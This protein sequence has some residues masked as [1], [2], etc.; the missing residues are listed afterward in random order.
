MSDVRRFDS[1]ERVV[2]DQRRRLDDTVSTVLSRLATHTHPGMGGGGV[3]D[4]GALTGLG[5]D[6]HTQYHT[7]ARGDVRYYLKATVDAALAAKAD[8]ADLTAHVGDTGNPHSVT[9]TQVGLGSVDNVSAANLRDRATHT[10]TQSADTLTDGTT[11]KAFLATERTKLSGIATG[12]TANS[13]DATLLARANHTGTQSA[14]TL[15]DGTT[16]KA[17]LATERTKLAGIATGATANSS[18]ATLLDRANHTGS[19][20]Q[21]TVTNLTTDLA[22]KQPLDSDLTAIAGLAPTNGD[23]IQRV[24]GAWTN[25]TIAQVKTDLGLATVATTGDYDDLIDKPTIP[26]AYTDEQVRDVIGAALVAGS[27]VTITPDDGAD[28]ITISATPGSGGVTDH[29]AL[30]GLGDDDHTQY[31]NDT[32]GDIRYYTK[33]LADAGFQPLDSDLTTIAGLSV[34]NGQLMR[35]V[36]GAWAA[37]TMSA[38]DIATGTLP[39]GQ[40]PTGTSGTTV[41]LGNHS[42]APAASSALTAAFQ[43]TTSTTYTDLTT[44]GAA[45]TVTV[46][47]SGIAIVSFTADIQIAYAINQSA[48]AWVS[49]AVSGAN[50]LAAD[51]TRAARFAFNNAGTGGTPTLESTMANTI[52]LTGLTTGSTTFTMKYK[53]STAAITAL[54]WQNRRINVVSF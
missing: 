37:Y 3:T 16:N 24:S 49:F 43:G 54:N 27:N 19:Q 22:G 18:D 32:R 1:I 17:F 40:V 15:T 53:R 9:K 52:V 46:G 26:A 47:S 38:T 2:R 44:A 31:H 41:A 29:G 42:H 11:N 14:D 30:T 5:D 35:R 7:D 21:G 23:L 8:D 28:T 36:S 50:T 33:T 6:D 13:S 48:F 20:A 4:H 39:I 25:R 45:V 34:S 10:G 12:A 51:D